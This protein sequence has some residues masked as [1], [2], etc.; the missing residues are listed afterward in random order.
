MQRPVFLCLGLF[1]FGQCSVNWIRLDDEI[2]V[3]AFSIRNLKLTNFEVCGINDGSKIPVSSDF[4]R[5]DVIFRVHGLRL[6]SVSDLSTL[7][8]FFS[9]LLCV[10]VE[11]AL[12]LVCLCCVIY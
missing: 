10:I 2:K 1:F 7:Y 3:K 12:S 11:T 6:Y 5:C 4:C 9:Y 8:E